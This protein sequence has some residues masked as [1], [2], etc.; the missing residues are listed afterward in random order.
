MRYPHNIDVQPPLS[1]WFT[2][3]IR[4]KKLVIQHPIRNLTWFLK[5]RVHSQGDH[6]N[7]T[8]KKSDLTLLH[9]IIPWTQDPSVQ[10]TLASSYFALHQ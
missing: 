10:N 8:K 9:F 2:L 4:S 5:L 7:L 6:E 1:T 3:E